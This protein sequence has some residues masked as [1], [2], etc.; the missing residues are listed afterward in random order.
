MLLDYLQD[1][2]FT[3]RTPLYVN[4]YL[5]AYFLKVK[6]TFVQAVIIMFCRMHYFI[7]A[8]ILLRYSG[9]PF[10]QKPRELEPNAVSL[11]LVSN[12]PIS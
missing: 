8:N 2:K 6:T 3:F 10:S 5:W 11:G 4:L 7:V 1:I 9:T 12:F